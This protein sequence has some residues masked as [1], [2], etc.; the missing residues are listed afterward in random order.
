MTGMRNRHHSLQMKANAAPTR[1]LLTIFN[2]LHTKTFGVPAVIAGGR[3]AKIVAELW[4]THAEHVEDVM[5]A[6]FAERDPWVSAH[7][8]FTVPMFR[9]RFASLLVRQPRHQLHAVDWWEECQRTCGGRCGSQ[10]QHGL[11][12]TGT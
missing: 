12:R 6:F 9:H 8:G 2:D 10:Y 4:R 3:D 11:L 7:G 1:H 5:A